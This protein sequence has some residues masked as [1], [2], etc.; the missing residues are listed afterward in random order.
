MN[1]VIRR[2]NPWKSSRLILGNCVKQLSMVSKPSKSSM[3]PCPRTDSCSLTRRPKPERRQTKPVQYHP[4][5]LLVVEDAL[6]V[7]VA[8]EPTALDIPE[9]LVLADGLTSR[10]NIGNVPPARPITLDVTTPCIRPTA[11]ILLSVVS[12]LT[13]VTLHPQGK[14]HTLESHDPPPSCTLLQKRVLTTWTWRKW[15]P[16]CQT[17]ARMANVI[18]QHDRQ[19]N[20]TLGTRYLEEFVDQTQ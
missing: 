5:P 11:T 6:H 3:D 19:Q 13:Q 16:M 15:P 14:E 2:A 17:I 4:E 1:T 18:R 12:G 8:G 10:R 7:I 9:K 20:R